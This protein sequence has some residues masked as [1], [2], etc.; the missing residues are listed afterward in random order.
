MTRVWGDQWPNGVLSP[1][2]FTLSRLISMDG[3]N[4]EERDGQTTNWAQWMARSSG[5]GLLA[6]AALHHA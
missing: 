2:I 3:P 5:F 4:R 6:Q 1:P